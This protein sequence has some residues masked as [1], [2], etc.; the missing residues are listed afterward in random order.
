MLIRSVTVCT[1]CLW[2]K[3]LYKM[4][5][6]KPGQSAVN[7]LANICA[8]SSEAGSQLQWLV[9]NRHHRF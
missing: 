4:L 3:V 6:F 1:A 5:P 2:F 8:A 7:D 9:V